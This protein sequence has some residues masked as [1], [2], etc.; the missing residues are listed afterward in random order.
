MNLNYFLSLVMYGLF[1]LSVT[2]QQV[3]W[4]NHLT[5]SNTFRINATQIDVHGNYYLVGDFNG[6]EDF[7]PGPGVF[8]MQSGG[9]GRNGGFVSKYDSLGNFIFAFHTIGTGNSGVTSIATDL[10]GNIYICGTFNGIV[11]L[12]PKLN[13]QAL[14]T[15][16]G[17]SDCFIAKYDA[18]GNYLWG[19]S[20]GDINGDSP[21]TI[22]I[23]YDQ[24]IY[25]AGN[26][27]NNYYNGPIDFDPSADTFYLSPNNHMGFIM[28]LDTTGK[29]KWASLIEGLIYDMDIDHSLRINLAGTIRFIADLDPGIGTA[30][31]TSAG[32][33]DGFILQLDSGGSY[34]WSGQIG[35]SNQDELYKIVVDQ[36]GGIYVIGL[37][38]DTADLDPT[39]GTQNHIATGPYAYLLNAR[40]G[41]LIIKLDNSKNFSWSKSFDY[42]VNDVH[43][44]SQSDLFISGYFSDTTDFDPGPGTSLYIPQG[45]SDGYISRFDQLGIYQS[46]YFITGNNA[47]RLNY[48]N[49][50]NN[51]LLAIGSFRDTADIDLSTNT[52]LAVSQGNDD[53]FFTQF[54]SQAVTVGIKEKKEYDHDL[55]IYPNPF[56][57]AITIRS[58]NPVNLIEVFDLQGKLISSTLLEDVNQARLKIDKKGILIVKV[59]MG[60]KV[61]VTKVLGR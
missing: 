8:N 23:G 54:R 31:H 19:G 52:M 26:V 50:K 40:Y 56:K 42:W 9:N 4:T 2:A 25:L 39:S 21:T 47:S 37:F 5:V 30:I 11:D 45:S 3:D 34:L 15:S 53:L 57:D 59:Y 12:D 48:I 13:Q 7:D 10:N 41:S 55:Q 16:N 28:K 33:G 35:G 14:R 61:I 60:E 6:I 17:Q 58:A 24:Q 20:W 46:T 18:N 49:S 27:V 44:T 36:L 43:I 29:L 51:K 1:N 22:E 38:A 32:N